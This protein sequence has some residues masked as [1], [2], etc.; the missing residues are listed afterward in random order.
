MARQEWVKSTTGIDPVVLKGLDGRN[1]FLDDS[2]RSL[3]MDKLTK[4]R[5]TGGFQLYGYCLMDNHVH[6]LIKEGEELGTSIERITVGYVQLHY[7]KYGRTG[8][9]VQNRFSSEAVEDDQYLMM[10]LRYIHRNPLKAEMVS[11]LKG[12]PW[13]SYQKII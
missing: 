9:L 7:N 2:D 11:R 13:S 6:L 12:Y 4:A 10:V 8:H 1:I 3:F 5:E